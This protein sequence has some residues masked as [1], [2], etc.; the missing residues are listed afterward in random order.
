MSGGTKKVYKWTRRT[1]PTEEET[2]KLTVTGLSVSQTSGMSTSSSTQSESAVDMH[3]LREKCEKLLPYA[4]YDKNNL[5]TKVY[6]TFIEV[7]NLGAK[8]SGTEQ[9]SVFHDTVT[10]I[11]N[12]KGK[13]TKGS[14]A[15]QFI[16][17]IYNKSGCDH[18]CAGNFP[19]KNYNKDSFCSTHVAVYDKGDIN[20]HYSPSTPSDTLLV[21][22]SSNK[23]SLNK[24]T[25]TELKSKGISKVKI[26]SKGPNGE[27]QLSTHSLDSLCDKKRE[28]NCES[29]DYLLWIML[30][31]VLIII[32][33]AFFWNY[34]KYHS[35][36][37]PE[38]VARHD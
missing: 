35:A 36:S 24:K 2:N 7:V 12:A 25:A 18:G 1:S 4:S 20:L 31:I 8:L 16:G 38:T 19:V 23:I 14:V 37:I 3:S 29:N 33:I 30:L 32:V 28:K 10:Q 26:S 17:C 27:N 13:P 21:H 9:Y 22:S 5:P 6:A 34:Y 11:F 15:E